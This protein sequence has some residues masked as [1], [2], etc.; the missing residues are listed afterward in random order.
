MSE[1]TR[2]ATIAA[3]RQE[4]VEQAALLDKLVGMASAAINPANQVIADPL[5]RLEE[6]AAK[7]DE[8]R[9]AER[10]RCAKVAERMFPRGSAHT[11]ASENA[12]LYR[13]QEA[14]CEQIAAAIRALRDPG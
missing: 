9:A 10:E 13:A 11:Y 6:W 1:M 4:I 8:A 12:D 3:L 2:D 5:L 14:T 7:Y